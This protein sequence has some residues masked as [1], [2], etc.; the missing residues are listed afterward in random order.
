SQ[1]FPRE[2]VQLNA[3]SQAAVQVHQQVK[4]FAAQMFHRL[5]GAQ[6][7]KIE[8][9]AVK[10]DDAIELPEFGNQSLGIRLKPAPELVLCV[11]RDGDRDAE[12]R[13]TRPAALDF[14]R[15]A[16]RFNIKENFA[17]QVGKKA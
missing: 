4:R 12:A 3:V 15:Q 9:V 14:M 2:V 10:G 6:N 16:E 5:V 7:F 11:P 17:G 8:A 13:D 1:G